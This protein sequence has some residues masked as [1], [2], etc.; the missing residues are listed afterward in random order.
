MIFKQLK[1][2]EITRPFVLNNQ[3]TIYGQLSFEIIEKLLYKEHNTI[4]KDRLQ[5]DIDKMIFPDLIASLLQ[6][7]YKR[8]FV[9]RTAFRDA[10]ASIPLFLTNKD[11]NCEFLGLVRKGEEENINTKLDFFKS[12]VSSD[13]GYE[14]TESV[15]KINSL[16]NIEDFKDSCN[17]FFVAG[18]QSIEMLDPRVRKTAIV[19]SEL[20]KSDIINGE[21]IKVVLSGWNNAKEGKYQ[22]VKFSNESAI[23]TNLLLHKLEHYLCEEVEKSFSYKNI[24]PEMDS[25]DTNQ[26]IIGLIKVA[27]EIIESNV[28]RFEKI[29]FFVVSS[30]FH[31]LQ[32]QDGIKK[33]MY[34]T[35]SD[36]NSL[37]TDKIKYDFFYLGAENP[38]YFFK[39]S[40]DAYMKLLFSWTIF[41]NF[42]FL[43]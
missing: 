2:N 7:L 23:M 10:L 11:N 33:Q 25:S 41:K 6:N 27:K 26:N 36:L 19:I 42:K 17:I 34:K 1:N 15:E 22:K 37:F 13:N 30:S 24:I 14:Y 8:G 39:P 5:K 21:N 12:F 35:D 28:D 4:F 40:D 3:E 32:I 20:I 38:L 16:F 18:C 31:L 9:K 29:N 43:K